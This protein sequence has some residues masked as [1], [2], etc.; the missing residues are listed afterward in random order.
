MFKQP[1]GRQEKN[2]DKKERGKV[3]S[4]RKYEMVNLSPNV[5]IITVN[6]QTEFKNDPT[7][8]CL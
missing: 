4:E 6:W 8:F 7:I 5:S 3:Q 1:R 2:R